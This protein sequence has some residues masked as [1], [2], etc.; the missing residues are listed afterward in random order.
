MNQ[1]LQNNSPMKPISTLT[2]VLLGGLLLAGCNGKQSAEPS[3]PDVS[4]AEAQAIAKEAYIFGFPVVMNYKTMWSYS[5]DTESPDYKGP[6]NQVSCAARLFTPEDKAVVTPNADT[7][8]CMF[9]MDVRA[10]PLVLSVPE[11]EPDR[12]YHFQLVDLYTH[13]FAYVG[14]LTTG[15]DA[16]KVLIAG[17]GWDGEK[18]EGIT[19]VVR[20]ETGFV[21]NVTRTQ[22]FGPDDLDKVKGIQ[23]SYDLQP[24][25]TFLGVKAPPAAPQP[26]FPEW[27]EGSQFDERFFG[28]LDFMMGLLGRPA[29]GDQKLWDDL[30]RLGIGSAGDFELSALPHETQE[31]LKAGVKEGFAEIEAFIEKSSKDPLG[32]AKTL[33]RRVLF[34]VSGLVK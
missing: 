9:W 13:N 27:E 18:P 17:P 1:K 30:A 14:T 4:L 24:L 32:S 16:G 20:S 28:Y 25:S 2:F 15:N 33:G 7:P 29:E 3:G 8:Y 10:E 26:D 6:F 23:A 21:F 34:E 5:I 22:L 11:M 12:F 31:A 19:D